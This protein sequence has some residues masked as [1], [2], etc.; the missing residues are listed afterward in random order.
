MAYFRCGSDS[1]GGGSTGY[2]WD[3]YTT[4]AMNSSRKGTLN[5]LVSGKSYIMVFMFTTGSTSVNAIISS[6]SNTIGLT[7][8]ASGR[9]QPYSSVSTLLCW[10]VYR[11]TANSTSSTITASATPTSTTPTCTVL[12]Y[13][14]V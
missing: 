12:L 14:E 1:G 4:V 5:G 7:K 9:D 11:F 10:S 8:L 2:D 6:M 13:K 3:T